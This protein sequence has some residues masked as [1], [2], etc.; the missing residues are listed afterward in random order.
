[1]KSPSFAATARPWRL[2]GS[3]GTALLTA[4]CALALDAGCVETPCGPRLSCDP[5]AEAADDDTP[6]IPAP[7]CPVEPKEG[8]VAEDGCGVFASSS[9]GDDANPGTRAAPVK[10]MA[11]AIELAAQR[12]IPRVHACFETFPE[13]V[14]VRGNLEIWGGFDCKNEWIHASSHEDTVLEPESDEVPLTFEA[15]STSTIFDVTAHAVPASTPGGSSIGAVAL[16][17]AVVHIHRG[18]LIG[19]NG[20]RGGD[21]APS[22]PMNQSAT[23][24]THGVFGQDA[25]TEDFVTGAEPVQTVC[26]EQGSMERARW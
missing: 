14:R 13:A 19:E 3:A 16:E 4:S 26:E 9:L 1:V 11:R 6:P 21:G 2:T 8:V 24:G 5:P 25:C 17:G 15:K 20:A 7:L 22:H 18:K 12:I 23:A 10:T